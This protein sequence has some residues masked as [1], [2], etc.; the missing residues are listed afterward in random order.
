MKNMLVAIV[1]LMFGPIAVASEDAT[2]PFTISRIKVTTS[3]GRL[4][5][6]PVGATESKNS[7]CTQQGVYALHKDD[8]LFNQIQ[9]VAMTAAAASKPIIVWISTDPGDCLNG[10]QRITAIEVDF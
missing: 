8:D 4:L 1:L 2:D 5:I 6:N 7:S 10:Y 9:S 3:P